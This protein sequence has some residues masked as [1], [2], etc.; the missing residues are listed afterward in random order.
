MNKNQ[1][2]RQ[3]T[4]TA[5][6][7]GA[8]VLTLLLS[9]K[10]GAI[11][12]FVTIAIACSYEY[13]RM[14][15]FK[16]NNRLLI[17]VSLTFVAIALISSF[18][19]GS[20]LFY[21]LVIFSCVAMIAGIVHLFIPFINHKKTFWLVSI[22]Y[23]GLPLG[24][25]IS[26][27]YHTDVYPKYLTIILISMIWVSDTFAY[28]FGSRI[29]R[30]KLLERISPKKTWEG[31]I[32]GGIGTYI[33]G[34]IFSRYFDQLPLM[35]WMLTATVVWII[36]TFGDLVES[37]IKRKYDVKDSGKLLPG[38]GGIFDRF[39]SFIYILPFILFLLLEFKF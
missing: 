22:C 39:D 28:L 12:L 5:I 15:F 13:V 31:F 19:P 32:G 7:F 38:H 20:S 6:V 27:V 11:I 9:G 36:G 25:I 34:Y 21:G 8:I 14:V 37:S 3:R 1:V 30:T 10:L 17:S 24:L 2:L 29:G 16:N 26:Y 4:M 18:H 35:F 23:F 33:L